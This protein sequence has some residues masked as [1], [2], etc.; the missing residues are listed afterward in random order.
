MHSWERLCRE[1]GIDFDPHESSE[2]L[3]RRLR[4][5]EAEVGGM[6]FERPKPID[7]SDMLVFASDDA[8]MRWS[9]VAAGLEPLGTLA[10]RALY[11]DRLEDEAGAH[12]VYEVDPIQR[13]AR[14]ADDL[15]DVLLGGEWMR[16]DADDPW[17][18]HPRS[19]E[20]VVPLL[21]RLHP[22]ELF[23]AHR[24]RH[25]PEPPPTPQ[26]IGLGPGWIRGAMVYLLASF[27]RTKRVMLPEGADLSELLGV[28]HDLIARLEDLE[29]AIV[30][31]EVPE[32][33]ALMALHDDERIA[34]AA[35]Q[36]M[37]RFD[38]A[39]GRTTH[40]FAAPHASDHASNADVRAALRAAVKT[41]LKKELLELEDGGRTQLEDEL[42]ESFFK[43]VGL[44][45]R[46]VHVDRAHVIRALVDA[47]IDSDA[48]VDVYG[49]DAT[50]TGVFAVAMG[51]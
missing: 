20:R 18:E 42:A 11:L 7:W 2:S 49:D 30:H 16:D 8:R 21:R 5:V 17:R 24:D 19:A 50:L 45:D 31:D 9:W 12:R 46:G 1:G 4:E 26:F 38:D 25:W 32:R 35:I 14:D 3:L 48:V 40:A 28:Q 23:R 37:E 13:V 36:W 27:F 41:L 22:S 15:I 10:G 43:S 47:M 51:A 34:E 44:V 6:R 33:V 39:R 29:Q